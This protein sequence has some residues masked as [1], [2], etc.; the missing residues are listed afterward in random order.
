MFAKRDVRTSALTFL[1]AALVSTFAGIAASAHASPLAASA[2]LVAPHAMADGKGAEA[3]AERNA[4][5]LT[6]PNRLDGAA[7]TAGTTIEGR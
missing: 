4:H 6:R 1:A 7:G 2:R 3:A 5:R